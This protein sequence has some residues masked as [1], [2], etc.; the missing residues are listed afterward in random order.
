VS[1]TGHVNVNGPFEKAMLQPVTAVATGTAEGCSAPAD[2]DSLTDGSGFIDGQQF[3]HVLRPEIQALRAVAVATVVA[4]H[5]W[6][7]VFPGGFVGVDVFFAISG[8]LITSHLLRELERTGRVALGAFWARRARRIVPA[9]YTVL[10]FSA[11]ATIAVV[12]EN[13][14]QQFLGE[15]RASTTYSQNWH[16]AA[17]SVNYLAA[18]DPPSPVRHFWSLSLEEQFYF[19]WPLMLLV[20]GVVARRW[21]QVCKPASV[22][23]LVTVASLSLFC[24]VHATAAA[25]T[26]AFF[27]TPTR[28][29][30]FGAGGLLAA[31]GTSDP[32]RW[33]RFRSVASWAGLGAIVFAVLGYS[34]STPFPGVAALAPVLGTVALIWAGMPSSC[35]A[36]SRALRL[37]PVQ[38]LGDLSYS[39]YLWHWPLLVLAPYVTGHAVNTVTMLTILALTMLFS[40]LT[41]ALIED[42][43]RNSRPLIRRGARWTLAA[44]MLSMGSIFAVG[45]FGQAT[46]QAHIHAAERS[47]REVLATKPACFGAAAHDPAHPCFN[48]HLRLTVVPTPAAAARMENAPCRRMQ[49]ADLVYPCGLGVPAADATDGVALIGDSHASH[50]RSAL[51]VVAQ[52]EHWQALTIARTSCPLS[53]AKRQIPPPQRAQCIAWNREVPR[54]LAQHPEIS[55]VIVAQLSGGDVDAAPGQDAFDAAAAGYANAWKTLPPSV[56]HVIVIRDTPKMRSDTLDCVQKAVS[57]HKPAGSAC[58][59]PRSSALGPDPAVKAAGRYTGRDVQVIDM[60]RFLCSPRL[61]M[62]VIGGALVYR[63]IHHMTSVFATT[64]APMLQRE[65]NRALDRHTH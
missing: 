5:A 58:A 3:R 22:A 17:A 60:T 64:L 45:A 4:Y 34:S 51:Q 52:K 25:P 15:I 11:I 36:P 26:S 14:W 38:A 53:Q 54:W 39:V 30:E 10:L 37:E 18:N 46:L 23:V 7:T 8:Y 47:G 29:W 57:A 44:V 1:L 62:P 43:V 6:P 16:L 42:P 35:W 31:L 41:K 2:G 33:S 61:C 63:D 55:V 65:L 19:A 13:L 27:V 20:V 28:A 24:S 32:A 48:A 50:W 59:Q 40:S 56:K 9:A 21:P 49:R 12:P